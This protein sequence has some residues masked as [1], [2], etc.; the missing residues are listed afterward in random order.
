MTLTM[1]Y[2]SVFMVVLVV[3]NKIE[4]FTIS[5]RARTP[6]I[7]FHNTYSSAVFLSSSPTSNSNERSSASSSNTEKALFGMGC[8]WA[9]Q[10]DFKKMPGVISAT[11][12]YAPLDISAK[13]NGPAS[14]FSVSGGD[15]RVE[16]VLLEYDPKVLSYDQL[17]KT[18]WQYHDASQ[19]VSKPQYQSAIW[20]LTEEQKI[21]AE[22]DMVRASDAYQQGGLGTPKTILVDTTQTGSSLQ[23]WL[24]ENFF[25]AE[26]IHQD[27]WPKFQAKLLALAALTIGLDAGVPFVDETVVKVLGRLVSLWILVE[28]RSGIPISSL[29]YMLRGQLVLRSPRTENVL[30]FMVGW[31]TC[32]FSGNIN[33]IESSCKGRLII[34]WCRN[35]VHLRSLFSLRRLSQPVAC[36]CII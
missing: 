2:L 36:S 15:G 10:G 16:A 12:G 20:V 6:S 23:Q 27:F 7:S 35:Y 25:K 21:I 33:G 18:F 32:S 11:T 1:T 5:A 26:S 22:E 8:F 30:S 34:G 4:G 28:V 9:P 14:Y 24:D 3:S 19:G 29:I 17:L 31:R 13:E